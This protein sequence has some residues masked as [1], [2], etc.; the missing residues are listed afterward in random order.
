[1][2]DHSLSKPLRRARNPR[3]VGR[4]LLAETILRISNEEFVSS[5]FIE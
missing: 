4:G 3:A 2:T 1:V 5:L